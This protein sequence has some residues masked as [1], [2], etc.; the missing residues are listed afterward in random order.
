MKNFSKIITLVTLTLILSA[1]SSE[2]TKKEMKDTA[3]KPVSKEVDKM[4]S[5]KQS[6][7]AKGKRTCTNK[8][9]VRHIEVV[10]KDGGC[11]VNYTKFGTSNEIASA[12]KDMGH[13][14]RVSEKI[15]VN[16]VESGFM[17]E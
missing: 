17:C 5:H 2:S 1:C 13:C 16:L 7:T 3:D 9:D 15:Q 8:K 6:A 14:D 10:E 4:E 11:A 12:A